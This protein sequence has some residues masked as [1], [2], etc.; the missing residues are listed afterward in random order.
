MVARDCLSL[1][2]TW[3]G[4]D[5]VFGPHALHLQVPPAISKLS[6]P[7]IGLRSARHGGHGWVNLQRPFAASLPLIS[8][9]A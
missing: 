3:S 2:S 9:I 6:K 4:A 5:R 1:R 7:A 8:K